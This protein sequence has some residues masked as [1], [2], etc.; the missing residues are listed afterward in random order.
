ML[1][2]KEITW[3]LLVAILSLQSCI[4]TKK[5]KEEYLFKNCK[6]SI[7]TIIKDTTIVKDS[8]TYRQI[9]GP[10]QYL[11]N[12]CQHLC[13]SLGNLRPFEITKKK[14]GLKSTIK[15]IGN[16]IA[17][18]CEADSLKEVIKMIT[19]KRNVYRASAVTVKRPCELE[20]RTKWDGF[21]WYWFII[22][23]SILTLYILLKVF[24]GYV[25]TVFPFLGRFL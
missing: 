4:L 2:L 14:N 12:P 9:P 13:D 10:V 23:A 3:I 20:H 22:T 18:D 21:T 8:I 1:R 5:G 7:V 16:S 11:E 6:D 15:S 24:K 17:F 19:H 25:K